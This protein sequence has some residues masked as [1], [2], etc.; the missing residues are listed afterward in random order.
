M[1]LNFNANQILSQTTVF[2]DILSLSSP[3]FCFVCKRCIYECILI[4]CLMVAILTHVNRLLKEFASSIFYSFLKTKIYF[5]AHL[6]ADFLCKWIL[7]IFE[8]RLNYQ[9]LV[10]LSFVRANFY[11]RINII[12]Q[13][14]SAAK[15]AKIK[16]LLLKF[17]LHCSFVEIFLHPYF[18]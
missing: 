14:T 2:S 7:H 6:A 13:L 1:K 10:I 17:S 18:F 16:I 11:K 5:F 3:S 4:G 9:F 12:I 15:N 8:N